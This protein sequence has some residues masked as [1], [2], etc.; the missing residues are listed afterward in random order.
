MGSQR[1]TTYI[2]G[3]QLVQLL[4]CHGS[5]QMI[6]FSKSMSWERGRWLQLE[7]MLG[8]SISP[9]GWNWATVKDWG[10][11]LGVFAKAILVLPSKKLNMIDQPP[12]NMCFHAG[13]YHPQG[14][15]P[16]RQAALGPPLNAWIPNSSLGFLRVGVGV[17]H[18]QGKRL[19]IIKYDTLSLATINWA[20]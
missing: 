16:L 7:Q 14:E 18:E 9:L 3:D 1:F 15:C 19:A 11:H 17:W 6:T 5:L 13:N 8:I 20:F 12:N 10:F 2:V 4:V